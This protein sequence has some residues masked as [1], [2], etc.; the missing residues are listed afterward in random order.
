M[1]VDKWTGSLLSNSVE[2]VRIITAVLSTP[3]KLSQVPTAFDVFE[4][5]PDAATALAYLEE[6]R[7]MIAKKQNT[8]AKA[9]ARTIRR[10]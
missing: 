2:L 1:L 10:D 5:R 9:T 8:A 4:N 3:G 6:S 7:S